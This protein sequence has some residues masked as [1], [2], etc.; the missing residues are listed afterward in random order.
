MAVR[1]EGEEVGRE[2][3]ERKRDHDHE[4][5]SRRSFP[6]RLWTGHGPVSQVAAVVTLGFLGLV[7]T[8]RRSVRHCQA[9]AEAAA[10][11]GG[12]SGQLGKL[13]GRRTGEVASVV[14]NGEGWK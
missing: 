10:K 7:A 14:A 2:A 6:S 1:D 5:D 4:G 12:D 13:G 11:G 9:V 8:V 3:G